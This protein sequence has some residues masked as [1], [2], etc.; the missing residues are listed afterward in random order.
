MATTYDPHSAR[1]KAGKKAEDECFPALRIQLGCAGVQTGL[2]RE[3][4]PLLQ[5]W[6]VSQNLGVADAVCPDGV[7]MWGRMPDALLRLGDVTT[8]VY[9]WVNIKADPGGKYYANNIIPLT[10]LWAAEYYRPR[11][12]F[13]FWPS[14]RVY[15]PEAIRR[16]GIPHVNKPGAAPNSEHDALRIQ[17]KYAL[18]IDAIFKP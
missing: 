18:G 9:R 10:A 6:I 17:S 2:G 1:A 5:D 14:L 12:L 8:G 15:T 3:M 16:H 7:G 4:A 11:T 13:V